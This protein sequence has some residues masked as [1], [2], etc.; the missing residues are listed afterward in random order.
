MR[1]YASQF[2]PTL[3]FAAI[4]TNQTATLLFANHLIK[5]AEGGWELVQAVE[6]NGGL[7]VIMTHP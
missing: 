2:L 6:V 7:L 3:T 1:T 5:A 4:A